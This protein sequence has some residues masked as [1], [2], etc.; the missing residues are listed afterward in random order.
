MYSRLTLTLSKLRLNPNIETS[1]N[2][3]SGARFTYAK[4]K[5]NF[6]PFESLLKT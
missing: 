6:V 1:S 4:A 3:R 5:I 2:Y